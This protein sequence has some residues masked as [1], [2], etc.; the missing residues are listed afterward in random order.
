MTEPTQTKTI[1]AAIT[2]EEAVPVPDTSGTSAECSEVSSEKGDIN[3]CRDEAD[4]LRHEID[5]LKTQ[6]EES[7]RAQQ[8]L[9]GELGE[10]HTLFPDAALSGIPEEVWNQVRQ[11]IPLAASYALYEKKAGIQSRKA[12]EINQR[13]A[14]R[15]AGIVGQNTSPEFYTPDEVRA[16]SRSEVHNN[17]DK[18]L[19]SMKKWN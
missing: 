11:G 7:R 10:F 18:I 1:P 13:N 9:A 2:S 3:S 4:A 5:M 16:M 19:R 15:S 6:L 14:S 8:K 12:E 17:Y